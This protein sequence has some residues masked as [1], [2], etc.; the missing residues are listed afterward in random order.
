MADQ[1]GVIAAL[2]GA[3]AG[4]QIGDAAR[5]EHVDGAADQIEVEITIDGTG[6]RGR[7]CTTT[8]E[9]ARA[10]GADQPIG[11]GRSLDALR[12]AHV[13]QHRH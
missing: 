11:T 13:H 1:A 9:S 6:D 2:E 4:G 8:G 3:A 10:A 12:T 7:R 5:A